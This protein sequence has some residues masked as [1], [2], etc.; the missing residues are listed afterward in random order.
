MSAA[1]GLYDSH[2]TQSETGRTDNL[3]LPAAG[4]F[5]LPVP[6]SLLRGLPRS[7]R[8][9]EMRNLETAPFHCMGHSTDRFPFEHDFCSCGF[10]I[11][12]DDRVEFATKTIFLILFLRPLSLSCRG[13]CL[14]QCS[15]RLIVDAVALNAKFAKVEFR[16]QK[17]ENV[18]FALSMQCV[19]SFEFNFMQ[20]IF[21]ISDLSLSVEHYASRWLRRVGWSL[22]TIVFCHHQQQQ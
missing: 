7:S 12:N 16:N 21:I 1:L 3:V 4:W 19:V 13:F 2:S 10:H 18:F 9:W 11:D 14:Q 6:N 8:L 17:S 20:F 5:T 15:S 22:F